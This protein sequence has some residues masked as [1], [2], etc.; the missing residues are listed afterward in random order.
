MGAFHWPTALL[1]GLLISCGAGHDGETP[2]TM[3]TTPSETPA[4]ATP[5][6]TAAPAKA[7][8]LTVEAIDPAKSPV[9]AMGFAINGHTQGVT[10]AEGRYTGRYAAKEGEV[11]NFTMDPPEGY[12]L[13]PNTNTGAWRVTARY[14]PSGKIE[15]ELIINLLRAAAPAEAPAL[16]P[17][18][19]TKDGEKGL[20]AKLVEGRV[21]AH[22]SQAGHGVI[23]LTVEL[24]NA[25]DRAQPTKPMPIIVLAAN[26]D[27]L[28]NVDPVFRSM[29]VAAD[30]GL[31][32]AGDRYKAR[33]GPK[34]VVHLTL[35][36]HP[37]KLPRGQKIRIKM[38]WKSPGSNS[39]VRG[40]IGLP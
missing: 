23:E 22:P 10:N 33:L 20:V 7:V 30:N 16:K 17:E 8:I 3:P 39:F 15:V 11:L 1:A 31:R 2:A 21:V 18:W 40:D 26:G 37:M 4:V 13:P 38:E 34:E 27:R 32:T 6:P 19:T 9:A 5:S 29:R 35:S 28:P 14:P 24:R 12:T 36:S 25:M